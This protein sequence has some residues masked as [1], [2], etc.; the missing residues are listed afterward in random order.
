[1]VDFEAEARAAG[2]IK[3]ISLEE[4]SYRYLNRFDSMLYLKICSLKVLLSGQRPDV[5]EH[6]SLATTS[7][8]RYNAHGSIQRQRSHAYSSD[9]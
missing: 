2:R 8:G 4:I 1:M 6:V 5:C 3:S 9:L 7:K